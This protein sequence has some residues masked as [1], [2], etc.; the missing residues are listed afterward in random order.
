MFPYMWRH[1]EIVRKRKRGRY[2]ITKAHRRETE[3]QWKL[4]FAL[5]AWQTAK[6]SRYTD[7]TRLLWIITPSVARGTKWA[8]TAAEKQRSHQ[9][10]CSAHESKLF[11]ILLWV[12]AYVLIIKAITDQYVTEGAESLHADFAPLVCE[13]DIFQPFVN[14]WVHF[15]QPWRKMTHGNTQGST[16]D[17]DVRG[18][19]EW[20]HW[21]CNGGLIDGAIRRQTSLW[22]RTDCSLV[23]LFKVSMWERAYLN[24]HR[25]TK[26]SPDNVHVCVS[27]THV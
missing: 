2:A 15:L 5:W 4:D 1:C 13:E 24:G 17:K 8:K 7:I 22:F 10:P 25:I 21:E 27:I 20:E 3:R 19:D 26:H 11:S 6:D 14:H 12:R 16:A 23:T 9:R 18:A